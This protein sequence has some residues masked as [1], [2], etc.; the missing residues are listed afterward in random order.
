MLYLIIVL[1]I[2]LAIY[3][4][5][6]TDLRRLS[7]EVKTELTDEINTFD[8]TLKNRGIDFSVKKFADD[9]FGYSI[10]FYI[11]FTTRCFQHM[12]ARLVARNDYFTLL[13]V[14]LR[15][16]FILILEEIVSQLESEVIAQEKNNERDNAL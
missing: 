10:E 3:L 8:I 2:W 6:V 12:S 5:A 15:S 7:R 16:C 1:S 9:F 11:E 13:K 14:E 4:I